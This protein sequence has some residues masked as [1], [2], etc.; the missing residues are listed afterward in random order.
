MVVVKAKAMAVNDGRLFLTD[1]RYRLPACVDDR[2][3]VYENKGVH[4]IYHFALKSESYYGNYGVYANG[5]LVETCSKRFLKE[6]ANME[7]LED[8]DESF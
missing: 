2:T 5:L 6:L 3:M 8:I 4:M 1:K 7:I